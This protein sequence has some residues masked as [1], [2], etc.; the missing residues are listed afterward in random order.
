MLLLDKTV[1]CW[2]CMLV[3]ISLGHER[4]QLYEKQPISNMAN[5]KQSICTTGV[6]IAV[7][8]MGIQIHSQEQ[9]LDNYVTLDV[10]P[11]CANQTT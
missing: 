5:E 3:L 2:A 8:A 10:S 1:N 6:L 11:S 9:V 4:E 7:M